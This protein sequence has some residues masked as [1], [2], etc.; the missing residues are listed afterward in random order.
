MLLQFAFCVRAASCITS[1]STCSS[2]H[3]HHIVGPGN[4][5]VVLADQYSTATL[6]EHYPTPNTSNLRCR[7]QIPPKTHNACLT[8]KQ[9]CSEPP[10]TQQR[11]MF[12]S[13]KHFSTPPNTQHTHT[14]NHKQNR[15][16]SEKHKKKKNM[17]RHTHTCSTPST[18]QKHMFNHKTTFNPNQHTK[19]TDLTTNKTAQ[20]H[21]HYTNMFNH[22]PKLV[23]TTK[24][25][26]PTCLTTKK[27]VKLK[28]QIKKK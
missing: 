22:T 11:N 1:P 10:T 16:N 21:Q 27:L 4:I 18:T 25:K 20:H 2:N 6:L 12:N 3:T 17:F 7:I 28:K 24:N 13:T 14:F 23:K 9:N 15:A 8:T 5:A 19:N 26:K